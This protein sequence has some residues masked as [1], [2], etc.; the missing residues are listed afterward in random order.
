VEASGGDSANILNLLSGL[1]VY[2]RNIDS[3]KEARKR[4]QQDVLA[5][6]LAR[7]GL[8]T[9]Y[10]NTYIPQEYR[11]ELLQKYQ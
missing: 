11:Q 4:E 5:R 2:E 10:S 1:R 8:A 6:L 3:E 9:Q 7:Q